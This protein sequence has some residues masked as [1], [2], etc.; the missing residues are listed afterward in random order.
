MAV[1]IDRIFRPHPYSTS[2]FLRKGGQG[3]YIPA[4]Q[5]DYAWDNDNIRRL[6]EDVIHGLTEIHERPTRFIGTVIAIHDTEYKTVL[7]IYQTEVPPRV[8]T[9]IDGQQRIATL[10]MMNI[11]L[12]DAIHYYSARFRGRT[13]PQFAWIDTQSQRIL[14]TLRDTYLLDN[15]TGSGL[16]RYYPRII[17]AYDD[18]WSTREGQARYE[19]PLARL[20]WKYIDLAESRALSGDGPVANEDPRAFQIAPP[21]T[22]HAERHRRT[23]AAFAFIQNCVGKIRRGTWTDPVFP[24][25]RDASRLRNR[26]GIWNGL[27]D[28]SVFDFVD[29]GV[30]HRDYGAFCQV[31]RLMMFTRYVHGR[32]AIIVVETTTENDAFDIF[33]SLNTTGQPLTAYETLRPRVIEA[34]GLEHYERS[35]SRKSMTEVDEY[36]SSD[37]VGK[38]ADDKRR[39]TEKLIVVFALAETGERRSQRLRDQRSYLRG[40][41]DACKSNDNVGEARKFLRSLAYVASFMRYGWHDAQRSQRVSD[42]FTAHD[43]AARIGLRV[44]RDLK[45]EITIAPLSRFYAA[46]YDCDNDADRKK[47]TAELGEAIKATVA[48]SMFWRGVKRGTAGIDSCYRAIMHGDQKANRNAGLA[49][50][51]KGGVGPL[52]LETYRTALRSLLENEGLG[53]RDGWAH[54]M[55]NSPVYSQ[56]RVVARFLLFCAAH[57]AVS[58]A[59]A[60]GLIVRARHGV[61]DLLNRDRWE[62]SDY[63]TVEHIAPQSKSQHWP[64]EIYDQD[65]EDTLGNLLLLPDAIN[66]V[67]GDRSWTQ[68]RAMYRLLASRRQDEFDDRQRELSKVLTAEGARLGARASQILA[69]SK[70]LVLCKS[71]GLYGDEWSL[72]IVQK[73]TKRLASLAWDRLWPWLH[74]PKGT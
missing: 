31:L 64:Q 58:D 39:A 57:D 41:F 61:T 24:E 26:P 46:I 43:S 72:D 34:E 66:G 8:M 45:H 12:H 48:F 38:T 20:I 70:Y 10:L 3:C 5:R 47:R 42:V 74:A 44:L 30:S 60:P 55:A 51:A 49:R 32:V 52:A 71:V 22:R 54:K 21:Q 27:L 15:T 69:N 37:A 14:A 4:Y 6:F 23:C 11:A 67:L 33:E 29:N 56:S 36:L 73:R 7:P 53:S 68:K 28:S 25:L 50:R 65:A 9:L 63:F 2:A 40:E 35:P 1:E 18:T 19:S 62:D 59:T 13:Q 17:R 16:Y